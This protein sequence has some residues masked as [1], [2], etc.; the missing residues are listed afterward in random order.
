VFEDIA[1]DDQAIFVRSA[2]SKTLEFADTGY[3]LGLRDIVHVRHS[4]RYQV[5]D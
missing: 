2:L 4:A 3:R 5:G 1:A